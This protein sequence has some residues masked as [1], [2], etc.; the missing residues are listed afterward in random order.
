MRILLL[1]ATSLILQI[2]YLVAK[3]ILIII[4]EVLKQKLIKLM[5]IRIIGALIKN[6]LIIIRILVKDRTIYI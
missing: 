5:L 1:R 3:I 2:I 4:S 6:I